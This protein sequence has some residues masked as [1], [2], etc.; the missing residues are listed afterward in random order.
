VR[1]CLE[2]EPY[3]TLETTDEAVEF[4]RRDLLPL[5]QHARDHLGLCYDCCHQAVAYEDPVASLRALHQAGVPI[6]KLQISSALVLPR[7]GDPVARAALMG[8]AEP[9]FLHQVVAR[10]PD[11]RL[12]RLLDLPDARGLD[13]AESWRCHFH[14]PIDWAGD[15]RLGTTRADWQAAVAFAAREGLTSHFEVET[16]TWGVLP[17]TLRPPP[18]GLVPALV[19]ELKAARDA[20]GLP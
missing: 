18:G 4:F 3:T 6:G 5:G 16:Y 10:F 8:F 15:D 1:L 11:G 12:L 14:V 17:E 7:P 9:R 19:R 2:P 13:G 20:L